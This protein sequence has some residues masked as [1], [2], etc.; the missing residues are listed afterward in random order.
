MASPELSKPQIARPMTKQKQ[1]A[2]AKLPP[3]KASNDQQRVEIME[4]VQ[5][6]PNLY[7]KSSEGFS[8]REAK[9]HLFLQKATELG[10]QGDGDEAGSRL[11]TWVKTQRDKVG[12]LIKQTKGSSGSEAVKITTENQRFLQRYGWIHQYRNIKSIGT[13]SVAGLVSYYGRHAL[14]EPYHC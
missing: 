3:F 10:I 9:K 11:Q 13:P 12:R 5:Q 7:D 2:K 1:K 14:R 8:N 4:W 6:H